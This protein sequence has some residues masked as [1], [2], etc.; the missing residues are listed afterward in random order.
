MHFFTG[1]ESL[2]PYGYETLQESVDYNCEGQIKFDIGINQTNKPIQLRDVHLQLCAS[3]WSNKWCTSPDSYF[4]EQPCSYKK[5]GV[6]RIPV[7]VLDI[8][9]M[10]RAISSSGNWYHSVYVT[11]VVGLADGEIYSTRQ[12]ALSPLRYEYRCKKKLE[13]GVRIRGHSKLCQISNFI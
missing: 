8:Q 10:C 4:I 11:K 12:F 3:S 5:V 13:L 6:I 2:E 9:T 7:C 1:T